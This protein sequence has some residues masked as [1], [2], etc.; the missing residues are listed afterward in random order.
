MLNTFSFGPTLIRNGVVNSNAKRT[1]LGK[2]NPRTG[3]GMV[4]PG[5]FVVI[6]VDGRQANY[7]RGL[8]D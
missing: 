5:H 6:T 7:S 2:V 8:S 1:M 4:E 3:I